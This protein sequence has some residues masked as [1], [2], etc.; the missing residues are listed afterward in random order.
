MF[1]MGAHAL[2]TSPIRVTPKP[3]PRKRLLNLFLYGRGFPDQSNDYNHLHH[4]VDGGPILRKLRHPQP[5]LDAALDPLYYSP[6]VAEKH[7]ALMHKDIDLTHLDPTLK[8]KIYKII[9]GHWSVFNE[10]GVFVLVKHYECIIDTGSSQPIAVKKILYGKQETV[11]M[12][13]CIAS[14]AKVGHIGQITD[15]SWLFKALL[16][17]KPHQEHIQNIDNFVWPFCDN[18]DPLNGVTHVVAYPIPWRDMA[19]FVEFSMGR[20]I[21]MFGAP[22]GYQQLAV[23]LASQGKLAFQG[24]DAIEWT[25]NIMPFGPTNRP[26]SFV[27]FIYNINSVSEE[28]CHITGCTNR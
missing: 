3:K 14:L 18:Y 27:S 2:E 26:A 6:F 19:V 16:A 8:E 5:D 20:F 22:M 7:E 28:A 17:S 15:A 4:G 12:R 23:A 10:K 13:K 11:I 1:S 24:V 25:Y 9:R 21:W